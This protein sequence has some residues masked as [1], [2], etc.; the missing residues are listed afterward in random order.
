MRI[1]HVVLFEGSLWTDFAP[2]TLTRPVFMLRSGASTLLDKQIR[3]TRPTRLSLWVRQEMVDYVRTRIIPT[4]SV[5][6]TINM[7]L[8]DEPALM[9]AARTLHFSAMERPASECVVFDDG[10]LKF[11]YVK[12][13]GLSH[14]DM[15]ARSPRFAALHDLPNTMPQARFGRHW[16]DLVAW[17][18]ESLLTDSIHWSEPPPPGAT[19]LAPGNVHA[20]SGVNV[21]PGVVLDASRGPILL[22]QGASIGANSVIE[23]P[24]Y[25]GQNARVQPLSCIRPGT[26]IGPVCRV[27]GEI[28]NTIFLGYSN[29]SHDGFIGDSYIGEWVNCGAG[30]TTSNL[31]STYGEVRLTHGPRQLPSG[32]M[33]LGTGIGDHAK[34]ATHTQLPAGGY[35]GV[36]SMIAVSHRGAKFTPSF[37]FVTDESDES[38]PVEKCYEIANRMMARREKSLDDVDKAVLA[39]AARIAPEVE[40]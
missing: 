40:K 31:K 32:R 13:P 36:A 16:G 27:G 20:R 29:K 3:A 9:L 14:D 34:T 4:L 17:N 37:R 2:F 25:I 21:A 19:C 35:I 18:E 23:G 33:L 10:L 38:T 30:T 24:C 11:A 22:D 26:T 1:M 7:P 5:P 39:Y 15:L 8:D 28:S 12:A 6:V